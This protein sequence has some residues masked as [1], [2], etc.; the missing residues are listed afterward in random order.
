MDE[1]ELEQQKQAEAAAQ[2]AEAA[3]QAARKAQEEADAAKKT[4][5]AAEL[6]RTRAALAKANDEAKK[7]RLKAKAFEG[8]DLEPEQVKQIIEKH[9][10]SEKQRQEREIERKKQEGK[11]EELIDKARKDAEEAIKAKDA[12]ID[13]Y[14]AKLE[15]YL[16][17]GTLNEIYAK[18]KLS[19]KLANP[20]I[21]PFVKALSNED[22]EYE[23]VV[24]DS[25]GTPKLNN[26]GK[27]MSVS[28]FV[29]TLKNDND[30]SILFPAPSN[31]G[32]GKP[33][34]R[35]PS[36]QKPSPNSRRST[37]TL[38]QKLEFQKQYGME[39]YQKLPF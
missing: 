13:S 8:I 11:F 22:G 19:P 20:L 16:V 28:E 24:L 18:E 2:A 1:Q 37:M 31:G 21:K 36:G 26:E 32:G 27:R 7:Y 12:V 5:D 15:S 29:E 9:R 33:S 35:Q 25:D 30:Y 10:E 6:E 17:D 3:D 34:D 14:K 4:G 38:D 39:A 23:V